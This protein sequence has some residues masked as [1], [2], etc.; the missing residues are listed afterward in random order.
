MKG[1]YHYGGG[2][3]TCGWGTKLQLISLLETFTV[4][5][6]SIFWFSDKK[7]LRLSP[8]LVERQVPFPL[9]MKLSLGQNCL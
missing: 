7:I 5:H 2:E 4:A 1:H 8:P 6:L 9:I 3:Q